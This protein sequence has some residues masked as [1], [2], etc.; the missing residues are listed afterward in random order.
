MDSK[1][2]RNRK[3]VIIIDFVIMLSYLILSVLD[4]KY[5][6]TILPPTI[7]NMIII[8]IGQ[9]V[10]LIMFVFG[11]HNYDELFNSE[12]R[13]NSSLLFFSFLN[14]RLDSLRPF[15]YVKF[16]KLTILKS[17]LIYLTGPIILLLIFIAF[18]IYN[19]DS[20]KSRE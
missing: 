3:I 14:Y 9:L 19:K 11:L 12:K 13:I 4:F 5:K 16:D 1:S 7:I 6:K 8:I 18:L 15:Y 10:P 20:K 17:Y 2:L